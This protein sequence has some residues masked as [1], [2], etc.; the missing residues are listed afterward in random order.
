[1]QSIVCLQGG[2]GM[3]ALGLSSLAACASQKTGV[4]RICCTMRA[5]ARNL[6]PKWAWRGVVLT[7]SKQGW[8][9]AICISSLIWCVFCFLLRSLVKIIEKS[10]LQRAQQNNELWMLGEALHI[11]PLDW[12]FCQAFWFFQLG[13]VSLNF[14]VDE[15]QVRRLWM[16]TWSWM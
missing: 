8:W 7:G 10:E 3:P 11:W 5:L 1:M 13:C 12:N 2:V 14:V 6:G 15:K 4:R 16:M 9:S